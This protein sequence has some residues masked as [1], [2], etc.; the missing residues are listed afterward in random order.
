MYKHISFGVISVYKSISI[1]DVEPLDSAEDFGGE[2]C[3]LASSLP[4]GAEEAGAVGPVGPVG[5]GVA[6]HRDFLP[7]GLW[8]PLLPL[9]NLNYVLKTLWANAVT[10]GVKTSTYEF[11]GAQFRS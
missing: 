3:F 1:S 7:R 6:S 9:C 4:A 11:G 2:N 10:L 8:A 5:A